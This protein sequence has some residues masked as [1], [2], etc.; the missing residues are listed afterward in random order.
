MPVNSATFIMG[1]IICINEERSRCA[2]SI[3]PFRIIGSE[4]D[5]GDISSSNIGKNGGINENFFDAEIF[6]K[7]DVPVLRYN[8]G[9][10][11]YLW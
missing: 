6:H 7:I 4:A 5:A 2:I 10:Y 8:P 11:W 1:D 3:S 9:N